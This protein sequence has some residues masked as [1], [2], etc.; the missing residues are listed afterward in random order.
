MSADMHN[1]WF[2]ER[3]DIAVGLV[4]ASENVVVVEVVPGL[5][6]SSAGLL[7]GELL[8]RLR[9]GQQNDSGCDE[10][11]QTRPITAELAH[12]S[13]FLQDQPTPTAVVFGISGSGLQHLGCFRR[14][15]DH[16][17]RQHLVSYGSQ[18]ERAGGLWAACPG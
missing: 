16:C 5:N 15:F 4:E 6:D 18:N 12:N 3:S 10:H 2:N 8:D 13:A 14:G 1:A 11:D 9:S 17:H 7:I